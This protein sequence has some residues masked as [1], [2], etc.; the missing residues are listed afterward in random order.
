VAGGAAGDRRSARAAP[1]DGR[2]RAERGDPLRD[3]A[4]RDDHGRLVDLA[5]GLA[6]NVFKFTI[7]LV[8]LYVLYLEGERLLAHARGL[9]RIAFP[10]APARFLDDIGGVVRAVVFGLLGTALVQGLVAGVGFALFGVPSPV[11]LGALTALGSLIPAGPALVWAG[12]AIWL[13]TAGHTA[14]AI[15][16]VVYGALLISSIDNVLRP[17][18]ISRSPQRIH[19][20]V[21]FFGVLGGLTAFGMLGLFVGPVLLSVAMALAAEFGRQGET[22]AS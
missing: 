1:R 14:A 8:T 21:V 11:A 12:A 5:G 10:R 2:H 9:A 19:F 4:R 15:G 3:P 7:T 18:L 16:M 17:L 13:F 20:L 6:A 22:P